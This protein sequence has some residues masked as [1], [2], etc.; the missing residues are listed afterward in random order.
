MVQVLQL[1]ILSLVRA[2]AGTIELRDLPQAC[3]TFVAP[4]E[5][6]QAENGVPG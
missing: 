5:A 6:A 4:T 3:N 2:D 1:T